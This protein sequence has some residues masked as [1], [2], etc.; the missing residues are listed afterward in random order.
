MEHILKT[1]KKENLNIKTNK[2]YPQR[3][4][5]NT[6]KTYPQ[7]RIIN[8]KSYPQG[9]VKKELSTIQEKELCTWITKKHLKHIE[10]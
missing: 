6:C 5:I 10:T 8:N 1:T 4:N 3:E 9:K 7:S 2:T